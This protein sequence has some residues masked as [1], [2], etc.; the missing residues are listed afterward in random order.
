MSFSRNVYAGLQQK[1]STDMSEK[2]HSEAKLYLSMELSNKE[3]KLAFGDGKQHRQVSMP[4]RD[5][6]RFWREVAK[7]KVKFGL[8]D[9]AQVMSCYEAGRDGFWIHHMLSAKGVTNLVVDP[10]SIEVKRRAKHVKTDRLDAAKL[11]QMLLRYWIYEEKK[12]WSVVRVPS[13]EDEARR[14]HHRNAE[15]IKKERR[16]H[17]ARIRSLAILHGVVFTR[18]PGDWSKVKDW[19]GQPLSTELIK[20][21]RFEQERLAV[22]DRQLAELEHLR[23]ERVEAAKKPDSEHDA[24]SNAERWS[25]K[26]G[27][28]NGVG[29]DT[30]WT[31]CHE[32][33]AWRSFKNRREVGAASGLVGSPYNSGD[34]QHEQGISKAGNARVRHLM[35]ELAWR[36]LRFQPQS[37]LTQ[38]YQLRFGHGTKRM[39]R[40][41]IVALARKLLIALWKYGDHDEWPEGAVLKA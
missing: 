41:G 30:S 1:R 28:F 34:S 26:I 5:Q 14:R 9:G 36:W 38:W 15:R 24:V 27:G 12:T 8:A 35:T 6:T 19:S 20:E 37:A 4:A 2:T 17:L 23:H 33:L 22:L 25:A 11:L 13:I 3:W 39:R 31:L 32:F 10:A 29:E 16:G 21:L 40:V 18:L 7:A